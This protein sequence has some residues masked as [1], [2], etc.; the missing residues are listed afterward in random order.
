MFS[1]ICVAKRANNKD[2]MLVRMGQME[3]SAA[4]I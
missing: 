4:D 2:V 3:A 1:K